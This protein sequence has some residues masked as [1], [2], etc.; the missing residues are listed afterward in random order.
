MKEPEIVQYSGRW[1]IYKSDRWINGTLYVDFENRHITLDLTIPC[2]GGN[3][4]PRFPY[5]GKIPFVHGTL[6]DGAQVLLYDCE[7]YYDSQYVYH[8]ATQTVRANYC[9]TGLATDDE[10]ELRFP[11]VTFD[12]GEIVAW[13]ELCEYKSN[14]MEHE[15]IEWKK[16]ADEVITIR[17]GV[18]VTFSPHNEMEI[19]TQTQAR[20]MLKQR[21]NV[22]FEYSEP[23]DWKTIM[24]DAL[25]IQYFIGLGMNRFIGI[26]SAKYYHEANIERV[27]MGEEGIKEFNIPRDVWF[28]DGEVVHTTEGQSMGY[29]Y[30]LSSC[31]QYNMID[32]WSLHYP[33]L[34]PVLDLYFS[35]ARYNMR[36]PELVFLNMMQALETYHARFIAN[37]KAEY[38]NHINKVLEEFY[39]GEEDVAGWCK[40]LIPPEQEKARDDVVIL[41]S[42][43]EDLLFADGILCG[44]SFNNGNERFATK[45]VHTRNYYTHYDE[46]KN[47]NVYTKIE[48]P[49]VN[50]HLVCLLKYH[51]LTRLG[52]DRQKARKII[53]EERRR[54]NT[55][56]EVYSKANTITN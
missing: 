17:E 36:V 5:I 28:G 29:L 49:Y 33:K 18:K 1:R 7:A 46:K 52:Y 37:T 20:I 41:R 27:Y 22:V 25:S 43:I 55:T 10:D 21:I 11:K 16:E 3:P 23:S 35:S 26:E 15:T 40:I 12:F 56:Y 9:F 31:K 30:R 44:W 47:S 13:S 19:Q 39:H 2:D 34:K 42:R 24:E 38:K 8:Y 51:L 6:F 54:I 45:L 50:R 48:L 14:R 53:A 32:N 4:T